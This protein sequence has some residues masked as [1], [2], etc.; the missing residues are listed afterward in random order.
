MRLD[1]N[2]SFFIVA[3][4]LLGMQANIAVAAQEDAQTL[5]IERSN[6]LVTALKEQRAAIKAD[7]Q[8]AYKLVED[9]VL[10]H[11][12]F[13]RVARLVLGKYWRSANAEQRERFTREFRDFLVRIY[14]TAM[15]EFS[16]QIVS[17]AQNVKYLPFRNSNPDDVSVRMLITLPDRPPLQVNYSLHHDGSGNSW[18]I[19]DLAVE[20]VSL[21]TTYRSSFATQIRREGIDGLISKL[22]ERNAEASK[23]SQAEPAKAETNNKNNAASN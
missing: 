16:D 17:H 7:N 19:Y 9:I 21:A 8:V 22:A 18:K 5:I 6:Q 3:L 20:G 14:V 2:L 1:L 23:A 13:T 10:P 4:A 11:V 12:D 15:V